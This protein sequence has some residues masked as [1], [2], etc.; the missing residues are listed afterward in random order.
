MKAGS[1]TRRHALGL[2]GSAL[3]SFSI[4]E[5]EEK[6][7]ELTTEEAFRS[8]EKWDGASLST[9][10][11]QR[12]FLATWPTMHRHGYNIK[13]LPGGTK[14][15]AFYGCRHVSHLL[16]SVKNR[17]SNDLVYAALDLP[18][19]RVAGFPGINACMWWS[20]TAWMKRSI[21]RCFETDIDDI[22]ICRER[23]SL[24]ELFFKYQLKSC[25]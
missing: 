20:Y 14:L 9:E 17:C 8:I 19:M 13:K 22:R 18:L 21:I 23:F 12:I 15:S 10:E 4:P 1:L 25:L 11:I 3:V 2:I 7:S 5:S 24:Y 16:L 6:T